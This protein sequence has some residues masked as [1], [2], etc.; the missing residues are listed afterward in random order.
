MMHS[1]APEDLHRLQVRVIQPSEVARAVSVQVMAFSADPTIRAL[2]PEPNAYLRHFPD[3][4]LAFGGGAF[5]HGTA[6]VLDPFLG[7]ALWL[8]PGVLPDGP[9]LE[10]LIQ[11]SVAEPQRS[12]FL[13]VV[14]QMDA[15]HPQETHWHLAFLG[16]DPPHQH[17]GIGDVL[18][19]QTLAR[20][21]E[22]Y[23]HAYLESSTPANVPFYRHHGFEVIREICEGDFP[24]VIPMVRTPR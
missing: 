8:P 16:V 6:H 9:A 11:D 7:A 15:S 13:K 3:L 22:E 1:V 12:Q 19:N 24:P 10:T 17:R 20:V 2:W 5:V 14:E 4:V 18:L 23:V 21:D